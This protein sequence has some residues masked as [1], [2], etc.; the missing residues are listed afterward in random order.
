MHKLLSQRT[1]GGVRLEILSGVVNPEDSQKWKG[2]FKFFYCDKEGQIRRNCKAWKNKQKDEK[3][4][5]KAEEQNTIAVSTIEEVVLSIGED[6][7]CNVSYPY[8]EWVIDLASSYHVAPRNELFTSYKVGDF[9][10]LKMSNNSYA[11]IVG[12]WDICVET[13]TRY[14]LAL[15]NVRH[16][17]MCAWI[18][19]LL[20]FWIKKAMATILEM[21]NGDSPEDHWCLLEGRFVVHFIRHK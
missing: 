13:N 10:R 6:E 15:K 9:R 11:D 17:L 18:W 1:R 21:V 19:F 16:V 2:K 12:I 3:N 4:H 5:N 7:C 20:I 8:V 14:T